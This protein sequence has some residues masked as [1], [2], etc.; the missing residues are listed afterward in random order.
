MIT[1]LY[2][3]GNNGWTFQLAPESKPLK[4]AGA[5]PTIFVEAPEGSDPQDPVR[6]L[7]EGRKRALYSILLGDFP[8]P[9][10][11]V[12]IL[13]PSEFKAKVHGA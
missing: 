2:G 12:E 3:W 9:D 5:A 6:S 13:S 4:P 10:T 7:G 11:P 1:I 8:E